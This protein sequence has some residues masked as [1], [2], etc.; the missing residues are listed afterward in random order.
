MESEYIL[1]NYVLEKLVAKSE[2]NN[3]RCASDDLT[4]FLKNDALKQQ[5]QNLNITQLITCDKEII[6]YYSL[7]T[8][9]IE[10]KNIRDT[11]SKNI[12]KEKLPKNK[13]LPAIKIGRFAISEKYSSQGI[14]S[15]I[16]KNLIFNLIKISEKIGFRYIIVDAYAKAYYFYVKKNNF[17]N[18][19]KDDK[20]LEKIDKIIETDPE[21]TFFLYMDISKIK[22]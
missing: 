19:K 16:L 3:F 15:Q 12:I 2:L 14:G 10:L 5:E 8:D 7:L 22:S 4:D 18:L 13:K 9:S 21:Y 6:G 20:K 11:D 17:V 1:N